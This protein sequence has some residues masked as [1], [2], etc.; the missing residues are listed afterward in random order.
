MFVLQNFVLLI[1]FAESSKSFAISLHLAQCQCLS[2]INS[3]CVRLFGGRIYPSFPLKIK[4]VH[5]KCGEY[6][7]NVENATN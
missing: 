4:L 3:M 5:T 6:E 1:R 2:D 7:L